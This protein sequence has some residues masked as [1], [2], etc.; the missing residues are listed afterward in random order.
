MLEKIELKLNGESLIIQT[1]EMAK[2]ADGAVTVHYGGTVV[3][4]TAVISDKPREDAGYFPL[5]VEYQEKTYAAGRIPGGFF[6]R[7]G[8]PS[9]KEILTAR[10]IDRPIRPLFVKNL[11][12]E[13][14]IMAI[15]LSSDGENDPDV[16]AMVGASSALML[17]NIPF[18][19]KYPFNGPIGAVRVGEVGEQFILNPTYTQLDESSLNL[20][21]AA[22][23][24][25]VVVLEAGA[26][27]IAEETIVAAI[28]FAQKKLQE[29]I[30]LQHQFQK[31]V[32]T[33]WSR[34]PRQLEL[35][36]IDAQL[37]KEVERIS[38]DEISQILEIGSKE[39]RLEKT[40]LLTG[41]LVEKLIGEESTPLDKKHLTGHAYTEQDINGALNELMKQQVRKLVIEKKKRIGERGYTQI[42]PLDCKVGVLPRTHGSGLFTRGETQSLSV[43]TLGSRSD[44]QMVEALEGEMFKTF[45]LHYSFP[46]FSVGE[47][48]PIRGPGR[49]EIGHGALAERALGRVMPSK[50]EFPY[51]VRVVSEILESNGSS[52]MATVCAA[53]LALMDAGVP[54][55]AAV[56]GIAMG[57]VK[58][59]KDVAILTDI[60][61]LEDHFGDTDFKVAGT[62]EGITAIQVDIKNRGIDSELVKQI[63]TEAKKAR[64]SILDKM[65]EVINQAR[66]QV[67]EYAPKIQVLKIDTSKIGELIGPGGKTI[68]K[69]IRE[70]GAA[71]DV[72]D[73]GRVIVSAQDPG[74]LEKALDF[75]QGLTTEPEVGKIYDGVIKKVTNFG[76]FCEFMP[77]K[78]GLIHVS[79]LADRFV[80]NVEDIVKVGQEVKV[81]LIGIDDQSRAK[82]SL[83][84]AKTAEDEGKDTSA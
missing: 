70:T 78:E 39:K 51:T 29:I 83:K 18:G 26:N 54:I 40:D 63:L 74:S 21:I 6:K 15:V 71:I 32:G 11:F 44:E 61:G 65:A 66:S 53:S 72:E 45:M 35:K 57:L 37:L 82:L 8:R 9:E 36:E 28:N 81:K 1:G 75:I 48:R 38:L 58:E 76:A 16:L 4:V 17:A 19:D 52:S 25:G 3:L 20:V 12:N 47:I 50:D 46:P 67:S 59:G 14:Q 31:K 13:V 49:R 69:I 56:A 30:N 84:Q 55:K 60:L 68:R 23:D 33:K 34:T 73:D 77:N 7:E 62:R 43:T 2:Q 5:F 80:K 27:E 79:E 22:T 64:Y 41:Q 24:E 10:L 42:R